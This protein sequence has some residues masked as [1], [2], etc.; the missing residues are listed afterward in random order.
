MIN[1]FTKAASCS[2]TADKNEG[3]NQM[4][5]WQRL[6]SHG[7]ALAKTEVLHLTEILMAQKSLLESEKKNCAARAV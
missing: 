4:G 3:K 2:Y 6:K 5:E 1:C 7:L